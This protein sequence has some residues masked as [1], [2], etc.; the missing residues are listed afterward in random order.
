[1]VSA[2][3]VL[4]VVYSSIASVAQS[5][6]VAETRNS[7]AVQ[8]GEQEQQ[9]ATNRAFV[10]TTPIGQ[11]QWIAAALGDPCGSGGPPPQPFDAEDTLSVEGRYGAATG[12]AA[13]VLS[14]L[15][16]VERHLVGGEGV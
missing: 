5:Q 13:D 10:F 1:M 9:Q 4:V 14:A 12:A 3:T 15:R 6:G 2:F 7:R 8:E 16:V 11:H